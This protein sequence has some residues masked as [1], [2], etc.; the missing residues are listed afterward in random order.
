LLV[1]DPI[2]KSGNRWHTQRSVWLCGWVIGHAYN[3]QSGHEKGQRPCM[4]STRV[5]LYHANN[6]LPLLLISGHKLIWDFSQTIDALRRDLELCIYISCM[7]CTPTQRFRIIY[8]YISCVQFTHYPV[9]WNYVSK[10][11][12]CNFTY[13]P[14]QIN[15]LYLDFSHAFCLD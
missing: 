7:Q 15:I 14:D 1:P 5:Y 10:F 12:P 11:L 2:V 3:H 8:I 9:I 13:Y 6:L 4:H